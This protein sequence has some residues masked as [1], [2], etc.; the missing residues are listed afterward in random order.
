MSWAQILVG[1]PAILG[2]LLVSSL[3]IILRRPMLLIIGSVL[4]TGFALLYLRGWPMF[5][6]VAYLLP[7][8][9]LV[10]ALAVQRK[11]GWLAWLCLLPHALVAMFLGAAVLSQ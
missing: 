9:H 10:G 2:S 6:T 1:W 5:R 3:G 4:I 7:L 11:M 8:L